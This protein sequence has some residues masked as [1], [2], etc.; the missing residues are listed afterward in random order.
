MTPAQLTEI[1][2]YSD[3]GLTM[4]GLAGYATSLN[5]EV[6]PDGVVSVPEPAPVIAAAF[7]V[8]AIAWRERK[9]F[10]AKPRSV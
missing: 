4:L 7:L 3:S 9:R 1:Q 5:G 10:L 2:F 6:L 8:G